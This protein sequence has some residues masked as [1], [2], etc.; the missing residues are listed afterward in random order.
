MERKSNM[1]YTLIDKFWKHTNAR[2]TLST[3]SLLNESSDGSSKYERQ[4]S[5]LMWLIWTGNAI[6][7]LIGILTISLGSNRLNQAQRSCMEATNMFCTCEI[8]VCHHNLFPLT[9]MK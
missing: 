9:Y 7:F 3:E 8:P 4:S 1:E 5:S 2:A 6:L